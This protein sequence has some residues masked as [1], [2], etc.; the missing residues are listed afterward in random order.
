[1][2]Q[3]MTG[4][5]LFVEAIK[6]GVHKLAELLGDPRGAWQRSFGSAPDKYFRVKSRSSQVVRSGP[7]AAKRRAE[8]ETGG[9]SV[10]VRPSAREA[11]GK[12]EVLEDRDVAI[13][14]EL[15]EK[16]RA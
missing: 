9:V 14:A 4:G 7:R 11:A 15:F 10:T 8:E 2:S 13:A 3:E 12:I 5:D 6:I 1:M 16:Y